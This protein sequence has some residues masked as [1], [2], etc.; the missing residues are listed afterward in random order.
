M[1]RQPVFR[2]A[3]ICRKKHVPFE[4]GHIV[5]YALV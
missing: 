1:A 5:N 4:R 3:Q 2:G